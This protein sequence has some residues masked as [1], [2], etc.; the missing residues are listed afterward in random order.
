[1]ANTPITARSGNDVHQHV[2]CSETL[3]GHLCSYARRNG[4]EGGL[5][6]E[7]ATAPR[8]SETPRSEHDERRRVG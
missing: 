8:S 6:Y 4:E 3:D 2:N 1:M 5:N 7:S